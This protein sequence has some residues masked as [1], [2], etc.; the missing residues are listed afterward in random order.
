[1]DRR[2]FT[3]LWCGIAAIVL[4]GLTVINR[5]GLLCPFGFCTWAFIVALTTAALIYF[6]K[7]PPQTNQTQPRLPE[8]LETP[9]TP[10]IQEDPFH[11]Q[12]LEKRKQDRRQTD[13]DPEDS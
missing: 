9:D 11:K 7:T 6:L 3:I 5:F 1:M 10:D 12:R 2:Q 8:I 4:A 13:T